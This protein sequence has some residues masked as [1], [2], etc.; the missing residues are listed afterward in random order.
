MDNFNSHPLYRKH[1]LD[2]AMASLWNFYRQKFLPLFLI[3]FV[4]SLISQFAILLIDFSKIQTMAGPDEMISYLRSK[5]IPLAGIMTTSLLFNVILSYYVLN[6]PLCNSVTVLNSIWKSLKHFIPYLIIVIIFSFAGSFVLVLGLMALIIGVFFALLYLLMISFFILPVMMSEGIN[7]GH[8]ISKTIRLSHKN[9][10]PNMG[11]SAVLILIYL[12]ASFIISGLIMIPFT[13]SFFKTLLYPQ[14]AGSIMNVVTNPVM[15]ILS[16]VA[17][18]LLLPLFPIFGF[19]LYFN[20]RAREEE[21]E[22]AMQNEE[23]GNQ[24]RVEDLYAPPRKEEE[25]EEGIRNKM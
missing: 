3:A 10:W 2:S 19:I 24:V 1:D 25:P 21:A 5:I 23:T 14:D 18:A 4:A 22:I 12:V 9:F 16:S 6:K 15:L 7:I 13:G 8:V 17:N 11:W 20:G